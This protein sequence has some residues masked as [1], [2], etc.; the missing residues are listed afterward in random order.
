MDAFEPPNGGWLAWSQ[1]IAS[2]LINL[3]TLGLSN[4][5]GVFQS[6]YEHNLLESYSPSAISWIGTAQ[7]FLL[8]I[9]GIV[10]GPLYDKG[11]ISHLMYAGTALNILGL[12]CTSFANQYHWIFLSYGIALGLGCGA[13]YVPAQATIQTYFSTKAPL[14][15]GISM[16]GSSIGGILYPILFRQLQE[17]VGF[18]WTLLVFGLINGTLLLISCLLIKPRSRTEEEPITSSF[19]WKSLGDR[20][21]LLFG[22]CALLLNIAIDVPFY[23]VPTFV[24]D[25]LKLSP[26]VG[27]DLLAGMNA[28][29]LLGRLFL[30]WLARYLQPIVIWQFSILA[31]CVLLF[32]WSSVG[33]LP[34]IIAFII[35]YGFLVGGL[36]SLIPSSVRYI[37]PDPNVIGARLGLVEG[38]Q[39]V[40]FLIGPPIAGAI[41]ESSLGYFGVSAIFGTLYFTLFLVV[42]LFT[43]RRLTGLLSREVSSEDLELTN[44]LQGV[45]VP[46]EETR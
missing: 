43:W 1:V 18:G 25:K 36:I 15:N 22:G 39:G 8:S 26:Q 10:S 4:S 13:L 34:G 9:V 24:Q 3:C 23:F 38:F 46:R 30:T 12:L 42:G 16:A 2:F 45:G 11:Y 32:C 29:S 21:L 7:G 6:Y 14:A 44:T 41:L 28:S 19:N 31:A 37:C 17:K 5:F 20:T 40:G 35:L 33:S 27:D